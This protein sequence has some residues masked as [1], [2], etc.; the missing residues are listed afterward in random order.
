ML[1]KTDGAIKIIGHNTSVGQRQTKKNNKKK[2][3][4]TKKTKMMSNTDP[5]KKTGGYLKV[6]TKGWKFLLLI[7]HPHVTLLCVWLVEGKMLV[8]KN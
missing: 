4:T 8:W 6:V 2:H 7:R 3:N 1:K 5:S